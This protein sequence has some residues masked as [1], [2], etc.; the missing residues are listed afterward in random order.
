M[1]FQTIILVGSKGIHKG[2]FESL[3]PMGLWSIFGAPVVERLLF[4]LAS[5]GIEDVT[6]CSNGLGE[7]ISSFIDQSGCPKLAF[8]DDSV[9]VGPAGCVKRAADSQTDGLIVVL[10]ASLLSVPAIDELV[11]EH[12]KANSDMTVFF[13]PAVS[14]GRQAADSNQL[15]AAGV[16]VCSAS[17]LEYIPEEGYFDIKESLIPALLAGDRKV[18]GAV[19][20]KR[21]NRFGNRQEYLQAVL[22]LVE[23][24]EISGFDRLDGYEN[25]WAGRDVEISPQA[26]LCGSIVLLDGARIDEQAVVLG[27][28][29]IGRNVRICQN[30]VVNNSLI[31]DEVTIG[32][33]S[34]V[35]GVVVDGKYGMKKK[36]PAFSSQL[37]ITGKGDRTESKKM[38]SINRKPKVQD[39]QQPAMSKK[40]I[41]P[42]LLLF[43]A[44]MW[45]YWPNIMDVWGLWMRSDEF[46]SGLLVP[47]LAAYILWSRRNRFTGLEAKPVIIVGVLGF[48]F[49]QF[50]R[51]FG[52]YYMYGS[53]ERFS[54]VLSISAIVL[55]VLGWE[56][57][58]KAFSVLLFLLLMLPWPN[59]V[60]SAVTRPLQ[61]WATNSAVFCLEMIGY[62]VI[63]E[64]NIIRLGD[65]TVAVAEACNGLRM[66]TA[67]FVIIGLIVLLVERSWWEKLLVLASCLPIA[68][69]C[70]TIRLA[71]TSIAFTFLEGRK[72]ETVFHDFGG[73]AMMPLALA[74]A[75]GE[76]W[77]LKAL[78]TPPQE[79]QT[80]Q[81][82]TARSR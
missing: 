17:V 8:L 1:S 6:V 41:V 40:F 19:L 65:T 62:N 63:Q 48:V 68:L 50:V 77:V 43:A 47:F 9:P 21:V 53:L 38:K 78:T 15:K 24:A 56:F 25:V 44:F 37:E 46:S 4:G 49:A 58:R 45:S 18:S 76:F 27:P 31:W 66:I 74:I 3:M 57:F 36:I 35:S 64:G 81:I 32:P 20:S 80:R 55:M 60:Q 12:K 7:L 42:C 10:E 39:C 82:V 11:A 13:E 79:T 16:Y 23:N 67:F 59:Q 69:L 14:R 33:E 22:D 73:Y 70:N 34:G 61:G 28:A 29:V 54:I 72:W 5:Q 26:K 2:E 51:L 71:L 30:S 75:V 52:T